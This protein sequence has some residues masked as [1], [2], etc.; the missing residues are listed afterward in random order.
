MYTLYICI[1]RVWV[2]WYIY[3]VCD[4]KT[5]YGML[6]FKIL[7]SWEVVLLYHPLAKSKRIQF[8]ESWIL[9]RVEV[10]TNT[11]E[12]QYHYVFRIHVHSLCCHL[13]ETIK[14]INTICW[15]NDS[16]SL[17]LRF[18]S[19]S[20]L[21]QSGHHRG[22]AISLLFQRDGGGWHGASAGRLKREKEQNKGLAVGLN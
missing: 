12:L 22:Q 4:N 6:H 10:H 17:K 15:S 11:L 16:C 7:P 2:K 3:T 21:T 8:N 1:R 18:C 9:H 13:H 5:V 20:R 19:Q 14:L